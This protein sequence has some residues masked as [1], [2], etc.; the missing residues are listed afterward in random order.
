MSN[1][2]KN[3]L[4]IAAD[5][6][7]LHP[8][9][10]KAILTLAEKSILHKV[11][12]M[13][14]ATYTP[15]P[16]PNH[17]QTGLHVDLTTQHCL[18]GKPLAP[19][20]FHL[21]RT[22]HLSITEIETRIEEQFNHLAS[23]GFKITHI[24]THQHVHIIPTILQALIN[25]ATKHHIPNIRCLTLQARHYPFY[26]RALLQ[27]GFLKQ[28]LKLQALYMGGLKIKSKLPPSSP[29]LVLMPLAQGGNYTKLLS[30]FIHRFQNQNAELVTHPGLLSDIANEPYIQ[31]REIEYQSLLALANT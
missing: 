2:S 28:S 9:I 26:M 24:D 10:D 1:L 3:K 7:G 31:G 16:L 4:T 22:R 11:S 21:L 30:T 18:G 13:A 23:Q 29:N 6:Y 5:D 20:P 15:S 17:I 14:N 12:I 25:I 8:N 27:C 19:S